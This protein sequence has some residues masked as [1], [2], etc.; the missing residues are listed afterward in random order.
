M[1]LMPRF[2]VA[3]YILARHKRPHVG[4]RGWTLPCTQGLLTHALRAESRPQRITRCAQGESGCAQASKLRPQRSAARAQ[5]LFPELRTNLVQRRPHTACAQ[6]EKR[7]ARAATACARGKMPRESAPERFP[8]AL[9]GLRASLRGLR[10]SQTAL[11]ASPALPGAAPFWG[12]AGT[13]GLAAKAAALARKRAR[14]AR[15]PLRPARSIAAAARRPPRRNRTLN[16]RPDP[17]AA[18][19]AHCSNPPARSP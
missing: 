4:G 8:A 17:P 6:A 5:A 18:T 12:N 3:S 1:A 16:P 11:R 13:L 9:F 10:A 15:K 7:R 14:L 19:P 2:A